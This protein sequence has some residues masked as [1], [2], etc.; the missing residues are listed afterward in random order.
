MNAMSMSRLANTPTMATI[1]MLKPS[2][3][4]LHTGR[5]RPGRRN[6]TVGGGGGAGRRSTT[7]RRPR[8]WAV[9][10]PL[11]PEVAL[12][13]QWACLTLVAYGFAFA[14]DRG[15]AAARLHGTA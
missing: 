15:E 2:L 6:H 11:R 13:S 10:N 7:P 3:M 14:S 9:P 4:R 8:C 5:Q 12:W 1:T